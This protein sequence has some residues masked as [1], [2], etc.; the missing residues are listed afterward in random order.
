MNLEPLNEN[1]DEQENGN[2][3]NERNGNG[4][5]ESALT[6]WNSHKRTIGVDAAYAMKWTGLMKLMTEELILLCTRMVHDEEDRVERFIGG[7]P[8]NIQGNGYAARSAENKRRMESKPRDNRGQQPPFKRQNTSGQNIARAYTTRSN[9]RKGYVG[10]LPYYNKCRLHHEGLCT[11]WCGNCKKIGHL[12]RN[13]RVREEDIPKTIFKTH[14]G[15]YEFQV[16]PFGL[17]NAPAVMAIFI[18]SA[19]SDSS[20]ESIG[21]CSERVILFGSNRLDAQPSPTHGTPFTET[22]LFTQR[23]PAASRTFQRR[24]MVLTPGQPIPHGRPYCYHLN[25]WIH[26]MTARKRVGPSPTHRLAAMKPSHHL[27]L[28]VSSIPHLSAAIIDRPYH[29]SSFA[30]PSRKRS[31]SPAALSSEFAI[32]LEV[33]SKDSFEP[34]IPRETNLEMDVD[35][36][37]SDGIEIDPEIQTEIINEIKMGVRD[38]VEVRVDRDTHP[39]IVDDIPKPA[40]E[41]GAVEV[42]HETLGDLVQRFHDYTVEIPIHRVH[43]IKVICEVVNDQIDRR[44]A[45]ALGARDAAR[46]LEP[47]IENEGNGNGGNGNSRNRNGGNGNGR[48]GNGN[49]NEGGNGYNFGGFMPARECTY[50]DFLKCQPLSFNR[51]ERVVGLTRW[52]EKMETDKGKRFVGGFLDNIQGNVIAVESTKLQDAIRIANNLMDQ[53]LKGYARSAKSKRRD[54]KVTLTLNTQRALVGNQSG[55]VCYECGRPG[56]F[57]KDCPKSFVSSTFSFMLDVVPSTLDTSYA[58]KL[59]DG[60]ISETNVVLRGCTL[61]L[62]GHSF[63]IELM[64]IELGS[65]DVIISLDWLEKSRSKLNIILCMKTD[66]YIQKGCQAYLAQVTSKKAEDKSDAKRLEDVLIKEKIVQIKSRIQAT[67]DRQKSYADEKLN[68]RYIGPFKIIAKVETVAYHLELPEKLSKVYSTFHISNLKKC[69]ADE[70]LAIS[71]DEI[72]VDDKFHFIEDMSRSCTRRSSV[73][74]DAT[75]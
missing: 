6:W 49:G 56:H 59:T 53:N 41:E 73:C 30:S 75:S 72:Q 50:Q 10:F 54:C 69:L 71:L 18:I 27:C 12:T 51:T 13:F 37:R 52:F 5:T 20:E 61:R 55:I 15:H 14:Y 7:L 36:V 9:E 26:M 44:L 11:I 31:R 16:M 3:G 21:T 62:L 68:P 63:D 8:D 34:Y 57:R 32:E 1:R 46:N 40:Q 19:S 66:K 39:V 47:L 67:C 58:V 45:G 48:N 70:T 35:V 38:L 42:T 74:E 65:F 60:R 43:D 25:E 2:R 4:G 33:T 29:D 17:T 24:V 22:T 28:L 64:P 23:S